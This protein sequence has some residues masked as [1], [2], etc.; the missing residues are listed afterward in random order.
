MFKIRNDLSISDND[1]E[2]IT[3][4]IINKESKNVILSCCYKPPNGNNEHLSTFL[5]NI[6]EKAFHEKKQCYLL[7]DFNI[8]CFDYND[9]EKV[10]NFYDSS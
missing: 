10:K 8:N 2:I 5:N 4:E 6:F 3:L 7:G 9:N 1:K